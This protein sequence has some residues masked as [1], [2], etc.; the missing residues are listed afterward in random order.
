M[1]NN[2]ITLVLPFVTT[3]QWSA[4]IQNRQ[5]CSEQHSI[6]VVQMWNIHLSC[7]YACAGNK[8]L[9]MLELATSVSESFTETNNLIFQSILARKSLDSI[10]TRFLHTMSSSHLAYLTISSEEIW[11]TCFWYYKYTSLVQHLHVTWTVEKW[12]NKHRSPD[13]SFFKHTHTSQTEAGNIT[14]PLHIALLR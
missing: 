5:L 14:G 2:S 10:S 3:C 8:K 13:E 1:K 6:P 11:P 9:W 7:M 4:I 12:W